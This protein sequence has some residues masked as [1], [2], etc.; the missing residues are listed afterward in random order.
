M[1]FALARRLALVL[2]LTA[3]AIPAQDSPDFWRQYQEAAEDKATG[4]GK[5]KRLVQSNKAR[6]HDH[7]SYQLWSASNSFVRENVEDAEQRIGLI[8][9]V[10]QVYKIA[11]RTSTF[12]KRTA[13]AKSLNAESAAKYAD[14]RQ[15]WNKWL[16][17]HGQAQKGPSTV[18]DLIA[19]GTEIIGLLDEIGESYTLGEVAEWTGNYCKVKEDWSETARFYEKA[20]DAF[21]A[22]RRNEAENRVSLELR[23]LAA[24][25]NVGPDAKKDDPDK[26]K[27]VRPEPKKFPAVALKYKKAKSVEALPTGFKEN[28][29]DAML[30]FGV[31]VNKDTPLDWPLGAG[32]KFHWEGGTKFFLDVE[33]NGKKKRVKPGAGKAKAVDLTVR[34]GT[35]SWK[36]R[37]FM[38][39][40]GEQEK[41]LGYD[42]NMVLATRVTVKLARACYTE[43][44]FNG[45]KIALIDDNI[46]GKYNDFGNDLVRIGKDDVQPLSPY[47]NIGGTLYK[48]FEISAD[49]TSITFA[50]YV[51]DTGTLQIQWSGGKRVQPTQLIFKCIRGEFEG[52]WFNFAD[53]Q[54]KKVPDGFYQLQ[55]GYIVKGSGRKEL[56][57]SIGQGN[58]ES[59][60]V[61]EGE[62]VV[63]QMGGPF[64]LRAELTKK[65]GKVMLEGKRIFVMGALE[66][67]YEW[68]YP[69]GYTPKV[70]LRK[71]EGGTVVKGQ[72]MR[73]PGQEDFNKDF[74]APWY[75]KEL[76]I[77]A[78]TDA[79]YEFKATM[80]H[81]L[82]GTIKT[83]WIEARFAPTP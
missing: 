29:S 23:K 58:S 52:G 10:A 65:G 9:D 61:A 42:A 62:T 46:N 49:G 57:V 30:W 1:T 4:F 32:S 75:P 22:H 45:V 69:T 73:R 15:K 40:L 63:K 80:T 39:V 59:F 68:F 37:A 25:H 70:W 27:K 77:K 60:D 43:G 20:R 24:E 14:A 33:G 48:V 18:E 47:M 41:F 35:D 76:E 64:Q 66:E 3:L 13:F 19:L 67:Q 28:S 79:E 71:K 55:R 36:Y 51:G 12:E 11:Y 72:Q 5:R 31:T 56:S 82:L 8:E 83:D 17:L 81:P 6:L 38:Q 54:P 74:N 2:C 78:S 53:G 21:R 7:I 44:T 50:E 16:T 26:P 34:D